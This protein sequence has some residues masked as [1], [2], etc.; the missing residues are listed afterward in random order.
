VIP[1]RQ[2]DGF[3]G[4]VLETWKLMTSGEVWRLI[5]WAFIDIHTGTVL[6]IFPFGFVGWGVYGVV[7][8]PILYRLLRLTPGD[9]YA[10][11]PVTPRNLPFTA[12]LGLGF[13]VFG[14]LSGPWW[15][16]V[17]GQWS[18]L[19]LGGP[20]VDLRQRVGELT[21][22]RAEAR[23]DAAAE[24]RRIEQEVHD[25]TQSQLVAIGMK[26]GTAEALL[27]EE[28]E[29]ARDLIGQARED[30]SI[31]LAELRDLMRGIRPPVLADRGLG[32]ALEALALDAGTIVTTHVN[33]P[34]R[35]DESLESAVYFAAR[36]LIANA[37][38][39]A[40]ASRI[41]LSAETVGTLLTV[42]VSDDGRGGASLVPGHGLDAT[43]RRLSVFD[44]KL[45][46]NSPAGGPT[47]V[48]IE[49]PCGS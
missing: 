2:R 29:R 4:H 24:L 11:I 15:L 23:Q 46:V 39:H 33:L 7:V 5:R 17:Q 48:R 43:R 47:T 26:L 27:D 41:T 14:F 19:L 45:L 30:S 1:E 3:I 32:S 31:A 40:H 20:A 44:G 8:L 9:W 18:A 37:I 34:V 38:K 28:P 35:F 36:E 42:S 13:I 6:A 49:V 25:G 10:F 21:T 16:R 22:S 12:I